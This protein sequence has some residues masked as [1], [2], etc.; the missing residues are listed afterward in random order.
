MPQDRTLKAI[1]TRSRSEQVSVISLL[2]LP[3]LGLCCLLLP[4]ASTMALPFVLGGIMAVSGIGGIVHAAAGAKR[5][6]GDGDERAAEHAILG[7]A[8]VMSVL[9]IVILVQGHASISFVGVMWGLLGLYKAADEID[10]VVHALRARRRFVLKLAFTVFEMVLAVLLIVSP[11]ANIEHHVLLLGLELIAYPFRI[12][13]GDSGK[14][15][16]ETEA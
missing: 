1:K 16:I 5:D 9:G 6:E 13:S 15:T 8:I 12:E 2:F 3:L 11:F 14:L 10:E 7:K 4:E